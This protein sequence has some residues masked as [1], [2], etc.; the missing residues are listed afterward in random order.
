MAST[1]TS[2]QPH[3]R[4]M[5]SG[6]KDALHHETFIIRRGTI[7]LQR[8]KTGGS[9]RVIRVHRIFKVLHVPSASRCFT[10]LTTIALTACAFVP[11]AASQTRVHPPCA[12]CIALSVRPEQVALLPGE[13]HGLEVF[14]EVAADG[15]ISRLLGEIASRG[16]T[17]GV[18][19][20]G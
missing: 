12:T 5:P 8:R 10:R 13:L 3:A 1:R 6:T 20:R 2:G 11:A 16:G 14:V 7:R 9:H 19:V 15:D 18:L 17:P 4:R